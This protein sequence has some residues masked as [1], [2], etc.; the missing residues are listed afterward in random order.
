MKRAREKILSHKKL[1]DV[2]VNFKKQGLKIVFTNGCFD[3]LHV[4]H[5]RYLEEAKE[6]GDALVVGVNSDRSVREIKGEN[7]PIIPQLARAELIAGLWCV[8]Y[9][10]IFDD[11]T[12]LSLIKA[13]K[14]D[15]LVKG[16]D[17]NLS[18]IVGR[19]FVESYGGRVHRIELTPGFSTTLIIQNVLKQHA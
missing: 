2:C 6:L 16:A 17:W 18:E 19:D 11:I 3:L 9:V 15:I 8:D 13:V 5:L 10:T 12:P 4:G 7:R 1:C 14:P